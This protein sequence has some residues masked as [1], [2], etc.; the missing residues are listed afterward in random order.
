MSR[1][2]FLLTAPFDY[3]L[4]IRDGDDSTFKN[5]DFPETFNF[6]IGLR[7]RTRKGYYRT[8]G[9]QKIKYLVLRG[10]TNPHATG[11]EREVVVIWRSTKDW[12]TADFEADKELVEDKEITKDAD[13]VFVNSDSFVKGAKS[14]DPV[15]KRRMFNEPE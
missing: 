4:E 7:V 14:L 13:E 11:G 8:A 15:F 5:V 9:K 10:R 3:K 12:S 6:L 2:R 1:V